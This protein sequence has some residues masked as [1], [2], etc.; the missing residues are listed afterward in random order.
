[1][2]Q[3]RL[4]KVIAVIAIIVLAAV[5][6]A[7]GSGA[8]RTKIEIAG[9]S[10]VYPITTAV[11][12]E[13]SK[14]HKDVIIPIR[15]TGT[16]GGFKNF[17][18]PGKTHINN[19]SRRIKAKEINKAKAK[20]ITP[21]EFQVAIDGITVVVNKKSPINKLTTKQLKQIWM[22]G[23]NAKTLKDVNKVWPSKKLE[24]Y[25][26][27]SASGTF[28]YF[29][30]KIVGK[31]G[32]SRTDYQKTEQD[33]TIV[34]AVMG[35]KYA[36]GYFGIAYYLENK[37]KIKAV[38]INGVKP[39]IENA[40]TGKY[41]PLSRPIFIYVNKGALKK[42]AIREFVKYYITKTSTKLISDVGYVPVTDV[43]MQ[44]NIK[45]FNAALK[46]LGVK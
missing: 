4:S 12:E 25:G 35:S 45:K 23:K 26:P 2:K 10:T 14:L 15:S 44:A 36:I 30:K 29:T 24:L 21:L 43:I 17:F 13:F 22:P 20:G 8:A 16:G 32:S 28:D 46:D 1:M 11:A 41:K 39:S 19:A 3:I 34:H 7:C 18:I 33:N 38:T 6:S 9:S 40:R 31:E 37:D 27:T 42:K 5:F